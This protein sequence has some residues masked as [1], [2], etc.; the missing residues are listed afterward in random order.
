MSAEMSV[1]ERRDYLQGSRVL[2]SY[3]VG[4]L[5]PFWIMVLTIFLTQDYYGKEE[6]T[7]RYIMFGVIF[8]L[9]LQNIGNFFFLLRD[10]IKMTNT[11]DQ[12]LS[13][14]RLKNIMFW[15]S[16]VAF[17]IIVII[18]LAVALLIEMEPEM[19]LLAIYIL[20]CL[21]GQ[22]ILSVLTMRPMLFNLSMM[23]RDKCD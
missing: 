14:V 21:L 19:R 5:T 9:G 16:Y 15:M 1:D 23:M 11:K 12:N 20:L 7:T 17:P 10:G 3:I 13:K 6:K 4:N 2:L 18:C 8:L 22:C